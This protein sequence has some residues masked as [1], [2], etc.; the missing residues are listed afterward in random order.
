MEKLNRIFFNMG[1]TLLAVMSLLSAGEQAYAF[2]IDMGYWQE[3]YQDRVRDWNKAPAVDPCI[4]KGTSLVVHTYMHRLYVCEN[5]KMISQHH[6]ALGRKGIDKRKEGDLKTP[7]GTYILAAPRPSKD[8]HI[9]IHV[10]YPTEAQQRLGY[11]GG[12]IGIHG[13]SFRYFQLWGLYNVLFDWTRGC[14]AVGTDAEIEFI[15]RWLT[16]RSNVMVHIFDE[17]YQN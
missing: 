14:L 15:S 4:K 1:A 11:T 12:A 5:G 16:P 9:F 10:G 3:S 8:F 2:D 17:R 6:V 7:I 13:P